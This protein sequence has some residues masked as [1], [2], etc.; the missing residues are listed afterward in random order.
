MKVNDSA[1]KNSVTKLLAA[2]G[3]RQREELTDQEKW[4]IDLAGFIVRQ[5]LK[6]K[7]KK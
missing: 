4:Y 1:V 2:L 7:T 6:K 3:Q 5:K